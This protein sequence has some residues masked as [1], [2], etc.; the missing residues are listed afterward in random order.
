[1][2]TSMMEHKQWAAYFHLARQV[3]FL[4]VHLAFEVMSVAPEICICCSSL[5][6]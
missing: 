4:P 3:L 6:A 5:R 1:M 2:D